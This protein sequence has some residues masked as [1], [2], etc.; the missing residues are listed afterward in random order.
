MKIIIYGLN[1]KPELVGIGKYTGEL[2]D[3]LNQKGHEVCVITAP[4]YYPE[5][6][7]KNNKYSLDKERDYKVFIYWINKIFA[8]RDS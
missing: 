1:F 2:A 4:K 7:I 5:W 3:F 6:K 8:G